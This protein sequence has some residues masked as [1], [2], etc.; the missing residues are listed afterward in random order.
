MAVNLTDLALAESVANDLGVNTWQL[1]QGSYNGTVFFTL[2]SI[3]NNLNQKY[4]PAAGVATAVQGALGIVPDS[5]DLANNTSLPFGTHVTSTGV[6]DSCSQKLSI[7]R[8]FNNANGYE[9]GGWNGEVMEIECFIWGASYQQAL[10]N[11]LQN[12]KNDS[13]VYQTNKNALHVLVHPVYGTIPNVLLRDYKVL[14]SPTQWR[15]ARVAFLF[16]SLSPVYAIIN[17]NSNIISKLDTIISSI[18]TLITDLNQVWGSYTA[19]N[20]SFT[21]TS[22]TSGN[23]NQL[24]QNLKAASESVVDTTNI[25][26]YL[27]QKLVNNLAPTGYIN[28]VL[29]NTTATISNTVGGIYFFSSNLSPNNVNALMEFVNGIIDITKSI[30]NITNNIL[31]YENIAN[32]T[33]LNANMAE[34]CNQLLNAYYGST[35]EYTVPFDTSLFNICIQEGLNYTNQVEKIML[36]NQGVLQSVVYI[37]KDTKLLLPVNQSTSGVL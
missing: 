33:S 2:N 13:Y 15:C 31:I 17:K 29:N 19:I 3:W 35:K 21:S 32:L 1:S 25:C 12:F 4:N 5:D 10:T 24:N 9:S 27:T 22:G 20:Q 14:H 18:L 37:P 16:E 11:I 8:F 7:Y 26:V 6:R 36:L 23:T 34:L 28:T 30:I